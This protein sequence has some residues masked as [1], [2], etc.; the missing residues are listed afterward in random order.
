MLKVEHPSYIDCMGEIAI[1]YMQYLGHTH[2]RAAI[3]YCTSYY[4]AITR[5]V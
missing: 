1:A 5:K 3:F 4:D 2:R